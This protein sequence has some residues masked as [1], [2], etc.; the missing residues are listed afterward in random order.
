MSEKAKEKKINKI[1]TYFHIVNGKI[2]FDLP[3]WKALLL[4]FAKQHDGERGLAVFQS[5]R[6]KT[7]RQLA[8]FHGP[9]LKWF[10]SAMGMAPTE[11]NKRWVKK[12]LKRQFCSV[13]RS[14]DEIRQIA[15]V[16]NGEIT[17]EDVF[18]DPSLA[19]FSKDEMMDFITNCMEFF[20]EIGG[21]LNENQYGEL[22][23]AMEMTDGKNPG[24][25]EHDLIETGEVVAQ[26]QFEGENDAG[27]DAGGNGA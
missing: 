23:S 4:K 27:A 5:V 2:D 18:D 25:K 21:Q 19:D 26:T 10:C 9:L 24:N 1:E 3:D 15:A 13:R 8:F 20:A 6:M 22:E 11:S 16:K 7:H 12:Y 14:D 17:D